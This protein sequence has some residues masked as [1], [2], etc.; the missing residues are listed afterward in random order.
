MFM[1]L[2]EKRRSIR[3]FLDKQVEAQ[4]V[5]TLLDA[6]LL[7]PSSRSSRP[8]EFVVVDDRELLEKLSRTKPH[9]SAFL[10]NAPLGI[11]VCGNPEKSIVWIEDCSIAAILIQ[12]AAES[13]GL[14]SC[15]IQIRDRWHD[16]AKSAPD[17]VCEIL[18]IPKHMEVDCIVAAGYPAVSKPAY[19]R[20]DLT[21]EK[22]HVNAYGN[23]YRG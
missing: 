4:K 14:G 10:V 19:N 9:G 2:L 12:L 20:E 23:L 5:R 22:V 17:Y 18:G 11:I 16:E 21:Y 3:R 13:I 8:W 7:S 15:W 1:S 6:A